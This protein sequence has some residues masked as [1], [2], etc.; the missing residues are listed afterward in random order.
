MDE[1]ETSG[2]KENGKEDWG[3]K[4]GERRTKLKLRRWKISMKEEKRRRK[5]GIAG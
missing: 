2:R 5:T 1:K 3:E 4:K